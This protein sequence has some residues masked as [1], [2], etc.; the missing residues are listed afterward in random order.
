MNAKRGDVML[1]LKQWAIL[2]AAVLC[3]SFTWGKKD[4]EDKIVNDHKKSLV[5]S[6]SKVSDTNNQS[7]E[8][9]PTIP[10][11]PS[12]PKVPKVKDYSY[13]VKSLPK[14]KISDYTKAPAKVSVL[15]EQEIVKL[16][17]QIQEITQLNESLKIRY[18]EQ[19]SEIQRISEQAKIHQRI[20]QDIQKI[21]SQSQG[22]IRPDDAKVIL[23]QE[24]IRMI[25]QETEKKRQ[26]LK[27]LE[28]GEAETDADLLLPEK[29][30]LKTRAKA[31]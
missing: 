6:S 31:S 24:K 12:I 18:K 22:K 2:L 1:F 20:L 26:F 15:D 27:N 13:D 28:T 3:F 4:K 14:S 16:Q 5:T 9:L 10:Q 7:E 25:E 30:T 11:I 21:N 23:Q 8:E 17:K 29:E 19:A